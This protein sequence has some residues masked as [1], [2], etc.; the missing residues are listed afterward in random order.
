MPGEFTKYINN[1]QLDLKT[2]ASSYGK[3]KSTKIIS[4]I[5]NEVKPLEAT[6]SISTIAKTTNPEVQKIQSRN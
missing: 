4:I 2:L 6:E 5:F 1:T 3:L